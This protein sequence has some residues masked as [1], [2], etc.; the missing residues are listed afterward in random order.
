MNISNLS[1]QSKPK[2]DIFEILS[3]IFFGLFLI[4]IGCFT[5]FLI[6]K[7]KSINSLQTS[8]ITP[9]VTTS[10]SVKVASPTTGYIPFDSDTQNWKVFSD[11]VTGLTFKYPNSITIN[12]IP[13]KETELFAPVLQLN[14]N[15]ITSLGS[16]TPAIWYDNPQV[17][18]NTKKLLENRQFDTK[19]DQGGDTYKLVQLPKGINAQSYNTYGRNGICSMSPSRNLVFYINDYQV[20]FFYAIYGKEARNLIPEKYLTIPPQEC[21]VSKVWIPVTGIKDFDKALTENRLE[22]QVLQDWFNNFDKI[23]KSISI[24]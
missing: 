18:L 23:V 24:K 13:N 9:S 16:T 22:N 11:K 2:T 3:I 15:K 10:S 5:T 21:K 14:I 20:I 7:N 1:N 12:E 19:S 8:S 17:A 4:I 6:T